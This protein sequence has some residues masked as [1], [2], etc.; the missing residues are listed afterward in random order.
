MF[1]PDGEDPDTLV[2]KEGQIAFENRIG[3][4]LTFSEF[5]YEVL[6]KQVD[7]SSMDGRARLVELARPQLAKIAPGVLHHMMLARL[8]QIS[9]MDIERLEQLL[10]VK[11]SPAA[12]KTFS[13]QR[14]SEHAGAQKQSLVRK[15]LALLLHRP[16]LAQ[17]VDD[18]AALAKVQLSGMALLCEVLEL[19][20]VNPNLS[21]GAAVERW[22]GQETWRHLVKIMGQPLG[23]PEE[24]VEGEFDGVLA[25]LNAHL[26]EQRFEELCYK[27]RNQSLTEEEKQEMNR[28][29]LS[30]KG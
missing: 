1:L 10:G 29:L 19:L 30:L 17:R 7:I 6:V 15:A 2:R 5:F 11:R 8:A 4:A 24:G 9:H 20:K 27:E 25:R 14:G 16:Q 22:R 28:L 3:Q 18:V 13:G 26:A 21:A 23:I 12:A